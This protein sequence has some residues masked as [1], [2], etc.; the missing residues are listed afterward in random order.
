[1]RS[2]K[3]FCFY[4]FATI[5]I[6]GW[7]WFDAHYFTNRYLASG[8]VESVLRE[9]LG[10]RVQIQ[11]TRFSL[12]NEVVVH[13][14]ELFA[15]GEQTPFL[16]VP[17]I[18]I[19][20]Q[21]N[22]L[23]PLSGF[24]THQKEG[25]NA[26]TAFSLSSVTCYQPDL[27]LSLEDK[28][29][30]VDPFL[31]RIPES[32]RDVRLPPFSV[33]WKNG[34]VE[35]SL[36]KYLRTNQNLQF[37]SLDVSLRK[38]SYRDHFVFAGEADE[39]LLGPVDIRG[40]I[41]QQIVTLNVARENLSVTPQIIDHLDGKIRDAHRKFQ[42]FGMVD[43]FFRLKAHIDPERHKYPREKYPK[44]IVKANQLQGRYKK[45]P[46]EFQNIRGRLQF[47]PA[48]LQLQN[49]RALGLPDRYNQNER[50]TEAEES[51]IHLSGRVDDFDKPIPYR[52]E[53]TGERI[54][55]TERV[56][57][58]LPSESESFVE[59]LNVEGEMGVNASFWRKPG[60]GKKDRMR[61]HLHPR[62]CTLQYDPF[63]YPFRNITGSL[64]VTHERVKV[65]GVSGMP[66]LPAQN[67]R[68][69]SVPN[70]FLQGYYQLP[71][72]RSSDGSVRDRSEF[73]QP[74]DRSPSEE[75]E[76]DNSARKMK[77]TIRA[78][79]A[80]FNQTLRQV[81]PEKI[82]EIWNEFRPSGTGDLQWTLF[83]NRSEAS[84]EE[85][86]VQHQLFINL[87][88]S[89]LRPRDL[90][91]PVRNLDMQLDYQGD[92][93]EI[94][95]AS[96]S[97][98][99]GR[100]RGHGQIR[101]QEIPENSSLKT[102]EQ[103]ENGNQ[104]E[105]S[106]EI[107]SLEFFLQGNG[108][109]ITPE[110]KQRLFDRDSATYQAIE[111]QGSIHF[112]LRLDKSFIERGSFPRKQIRTGIS[113]GYT[114]RLLKEGP[115]GTPLHYYGKVYYSNIALDTSPSISDLT[116]KLIIEGEQ[117]H[118]GNNT[119]GHVGRINVDRVRIN[120][121]PFRSVSSSFRLQ[122]RIELNDIQIEAFD[123]TIGG[124]LLLSPESTLFSL[125][126][127][128]SG[129]NIDQIVRKTQLRGK[130]LTGLVDGNV[131]ITGKLNDRSTWKGEGE[132]WTRKARLWELPIFLSLFSQLS[133]NE[134]VVFNR[135]Y[136]Q[137][138]INNQKLLIDKMLFFS[139]AAQIIGKGEITFDGRILIDIESRVSETVIPTLPLIKPIL[140][141]TIGRLEENLLAFQLTG[142]F[143][144]PSI[145][146]I[147]L[148]FLS[149]SE[150]EVE[151]PEKD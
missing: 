102:E 63:P 118:Q 85:S 97:W 69:R 106:P 108:M 68:V 54:P 49:V 40:E 103:T 64:L 9:Q 22:L 5:S 71:D 145:A 31:K 28:T 139:D 105:T 70:V 52:I 1:M 10:N 53:L 94:S 82:Q 95:R 65:E 30:N 48:G 29:W 44:F 92:L 23:R 80:P 98:S 115:R 134:Q 128:L 131:S 42:F 130:T 4:L 15:P 90:S 75:V 147:P 47:S 61:I 101:L 81:L 45:F 107:T 87:Q 96:G 27:R 59:S 132:L 18:R 116:G 74:L 150:L 129:L 110:L 143:L 89:V 112:R 6:T 146:V 43:M 36:P 77:L 17:R 113:H 133:L 109:A 73:E 26:F 149:K 119:K 37:S 88:D 117:D 114:D 34:D 76:E 67:Q 55:V 32:D 111:D 86:A 144:N 151:V 135:G 136:V 33:D 120:G 72:K 100:V 11:S 39:R 51:T 123:G 148:P 126:S 35:L 16:T 19:T 20:F 66:D 38:V 12:P 137:S 60:A 84:S 141:Q 21:P 140:D 8:R 121:F 2:L 46:Y 127:R 99:G 13:H 62:D 93:V 124:H 78:E 57:A 104:Q 91:T 24:T 79:E 50:D 122:D 138:R 41:E 125:Q 142:T 58:A 56:I 83:Q 14:L 7:L 3:L 25:S